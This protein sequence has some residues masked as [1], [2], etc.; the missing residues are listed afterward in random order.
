[1]EWQQTMDSFRSRYHA[2]YC[3]NIHAI[4]PFE[5]AWQ[6]MVWHSG[7]PMMRKN[8]IDDEVSRVR[9]KCTC[10]P[11]YWWNVTRIWFL[12]HE[13]E[14]DPIKLI[15]IPCAYNLFTTT[16][17]DLIL[18][19]W[20]RTSQRERES[21][22]IIQLSVWVVVL[23]SILTN[24]FVYFTRIHNILIATL[25]TKQLHCEDQMQSY[26]SSRSAELTCVLLFLMLRLHCITHTFYCNR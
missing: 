11:V 22:K 1:M 18:Q 10:S 13:P 25:V 14:L 16:N 5:Q 23:Y 7:W 9:V 2:T 4:I 12:A 24:L 21:S 26:A 17:Y 6:D 3:I 8:Y 19:D 15:G 20:V